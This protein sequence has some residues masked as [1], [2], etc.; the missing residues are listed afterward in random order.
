MPGL[1]IVA[2]PSPDDYVWKISSEKVPHL[3]LLFLGDQDNNP[4]LGQMT[5][6]LEHVARISMHRF[7][8]SVDRRGVLG[9]QNADVL[10]F[11]DH[12]IRMLENVRGFLLANQHISEA[13]HSTFQYPEWTPH[14]TLG[15]PETPAKPD[16]REYPGTSWVNFDRVALWTGDYEGP[17]FQL[18]DNYAI[19]E[20]GMSDMSLDETLAHYGILG[21]HWGVRRTREQIDAAPEAALAKAHARRVRKHGTDALTNKELQELITRMSLE[22][23]Y[24][25]LRRSPASRSRGQQIAEEVL[26][27]TGK[28]LA[29][30]AVRTAVVKGVPHIVR[31]VRG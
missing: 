1:A 14:L 18:E 13:Y 29:K 9:D 20:V 19:G 12:N 4:H 6:Y 26:R 11:A 25:N 27:E 23:Q 10:F 2:I 24:T 22:Q 5:R 7:G 31:S 15:Y 28:S 16:D 17:T 3:T 21:M 30:E 8:L